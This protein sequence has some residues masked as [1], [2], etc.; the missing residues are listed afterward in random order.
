MTHLETFLRNPSL[1]FFSTHLDFSQATLSTLKSGSS[2][3]RF[4]AFFD[5]R[6]CF[7]TE[8][9]ADHYL[10]CKI[11][12]Q[13]AFFFVVFAL[14]Y[15]IGRQMQMLSF[16]IQIMLRIVFV[17]QLLLIITI[18]D[19]SL[20]MTKEKHISDLEQEENRHIS[21]LDSQQIFIKQHCNSEI[22]TITLQ[23]VLCLILFIIR[24]C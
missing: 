18:D 11:L 10:S 9:F 20:I 7:K 1:Q 8:F 21:Y 2:L 3:M 5:P 22:K 13:E 17:F 14:F 6:S 16:I 24:H 12:T 4:K 23:A 19:L 15:P